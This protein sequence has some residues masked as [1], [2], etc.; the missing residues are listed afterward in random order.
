[1][2]PAPEFYVFYN[3]KEDR[4]LMEI[5]KL[6]DSFVKKCDAIDLEVNVTVINVNYFD[7]NS[8]EKK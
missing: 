7:Y 3:G 8:G 6:S 4:P 5:L 1:M 2:I